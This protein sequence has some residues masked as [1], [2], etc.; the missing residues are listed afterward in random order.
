MR[1]CL[2]GGIFNK[3]AEYQR[4]VNATPETNLLKELRLRGCVSSRGHYGPFDFDMSK[5]WR[6][7]RSAATHWAFAR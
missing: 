7:Q 6:K 3:S 5:S 2:V 1:V 4:T